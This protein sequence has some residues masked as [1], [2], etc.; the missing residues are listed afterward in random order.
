MSSRLTRSLSP[1]RLRLIL[2]ALFVALAVPTAVLVQQTQRQI[3][4][5]AFHQY[6]TLAD[7]LGLRIDVE[8]QRLVALEEARGYGDYGFV[9]T[10]LD[11]AANAIAPE[12]SPLSRFPM[13]SQFPGLIGYFQVDADGRFSTPLLPYDLAP[14]DA[15]M[16]ADELARRTALRDRLLD[17]LSRNQLIA[18]ARDRDAT[19]AKPT[20]ANVRADAD[21]KEA[22]V[23]SQAAFDKL[24]AIA[25]QQSDSR[26]NELGR[27]D[28]LRLSNTYQ[29]QSAA[30]A[31]QREAPEYEQRLKANVQARGTRKEKSAIVEQLEFGASA[32]AAIGTRPVRAFESELDPFELDLLDGGYAVLYRKAWRDGRR[33]I[34]GALIDQA[35]FLQGAIAKPF[36]ETALAQVSDLVVAHDRDVV[37][38]TRGAAGRDAVG[39]AATLRGELLHQMRLSAPLDDF[40]LLWNIDRLPAGPG[41]RVVA[42]SRAV[43]FGVLVLGLV[44]LYRLGLRQITLARQQ[45]DFVSAVSHELKTPLTSIRMY[46]E[47]L[48][49][50]WAGEDKKRGYYDFIHDESERLS[51]LIANVLQLARMERNELHLELKPMRVEALMDLLRSKLGSQIER[52]G[53]E[54]GYTVDPA[55]AMRE[56]EIDTDAFV[57]IMINLVDNALKFSARAERRTIEIAV[58]A[59]GERAVAWS[60]RDHGPGVDKSQMKKIFAL[61]YRPGSELTRETLGTGIGLALV[62]QLARAMRGDADV[63]NRD[64]GAEFR[65]VLPS[66]VTT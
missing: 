45:A 6:R 18:R 57:Q 52:A 43:L 13:Q 39:N 46:A 50:G 2:A 38:V 19:G 63:V 34:Q 24:G 8:L 49:E 48:R 65:L 3:G 20:D 26:S 36:Q 10:R 9:V 32:D 1:A 35:A 53:F 66:R 40:Q 14:A 28:D 22:Q 58:R 47:M 51:R 44:V 61:F 41:A 33:T 55:C 56:L 42:W 7:E 15:V 21:S 64:P 60:V 37:L 12:R 5:E 30:Q 54:S 4:F 31:A 23:P 29:R 11:S 27:L 16:P 62:R 59:Q 17:V 25:K